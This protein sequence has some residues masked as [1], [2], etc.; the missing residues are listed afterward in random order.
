MKLAK[1]TACGQS[2][3]YAKQRSFK[4]HKQVFAASVNF[5][6]RKSIASTKSQSPL[7]RQSLVLL[8]AHIK[9]SRSIFEHRFV[10]L[11]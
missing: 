1:P 2:E 10:F 11:Q 6:K 7:L 5:K 3:A 4:K 8:E 9:G